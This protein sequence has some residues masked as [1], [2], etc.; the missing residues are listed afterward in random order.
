MGGRSVSKRV[1][2]M[3][4]I[5]YLVN[6][7]MYN[8]SWKSFFSTGRSTERIEEVNPFEGLWNKKYVTDI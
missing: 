4:K 5:F 2:Y 1:F 8:I 6:S 3:F 7:E